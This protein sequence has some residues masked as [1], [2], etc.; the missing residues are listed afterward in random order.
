MGL[1][2]F[3]AHARTKNLRDKRNVVGENEITD[4]FLA[5]A[6]CEA[7]MKISVIGRVHI[8]RN[9]VNYKK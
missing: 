5:S 8:P 6:G 2:C 9:K 4:L 3:G 1:K 7:K